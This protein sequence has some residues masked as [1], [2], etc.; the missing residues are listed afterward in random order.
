MNETSHKTFFMQSIPEEDFKNIM[1]FTKSHY[2]ITHKLRLNHPSLCISHIKSLPH[3]HPPRARGHTH[4]H[5]ILSTNGSLTKI[6]GN[7]DNS[8]NH[9]M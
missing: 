2:L 9:T 1:Y 8:E 3:P 5:V 4:T 7:H 6:V